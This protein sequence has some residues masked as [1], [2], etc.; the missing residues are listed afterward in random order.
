MALYCFRSGCSADG[1]APRLGRG[2]QRFKSAHPD[3]RNVMCIQMAAHYVFFVKDF[4]AGIIFSVPTPFYHLSV[5]EEL[6]HH[7]ELP[8][9]IRRALSEQ[10]GAFHLG[11]TA[12]DV[13]VLSGQDRQATHFFTLPLEPDAPLPWDRL[14]EDYPSLAQIDAS[15]PAQVAFIGGYLCHLQAD[16]IWINEIFIP[17]FGSHSSWGTFRHRL[18]LH[19]VLRAYLDGQI[20]PDL[21][22]ETA[23]YLQE[24][25]PDGWLPFV[26]DKHLVVWRNYLAQQLKPGATTRTVEVFAARQRISPDK[27]YQLLESETRMDAEIFSKL[28]RG[29]L[30]Q[31][32][33]KLIETNLRTLVTYLTNVSE[34]ATIRSQP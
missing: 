22:E 11:N 19:N 15:Q 33:M 2:G 7:P 12:P 26:E 23:L 3:S 16:W 18:Y 4:I 24:V 9:R 6:L 31:Y 28:P 10:R 1:S 5:A 25:S 34:R 8:A 29:R 13:Q 14:L 20:I 21:P 32:R 17:V 30:I 27:Y